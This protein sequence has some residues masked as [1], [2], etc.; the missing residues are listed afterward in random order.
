MFKENPETI[1]ITKKIIE[2]KKKLK[3]FS[4]VMGLN[5]VELIELKLNKLSQKLGIKKFSKILSEI[6]DEFL[7][8]GIQEKIAS[9]KFSLMKKA[10]R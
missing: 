6:G 4:G 9:K 8:Q 3:G 5:R 7:K 10:K 2:I 1:G